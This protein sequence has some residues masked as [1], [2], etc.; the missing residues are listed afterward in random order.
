MEVIRDRYVGH[1]NRY[2][3]AA[4]NNKNTRGAET[5]PAP[6]QHDAAARSAE[7]RP[8]LLIVVDEDWW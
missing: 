2:A 6:D 8:R 1:D 5:P 3:G 4:D 7:Q